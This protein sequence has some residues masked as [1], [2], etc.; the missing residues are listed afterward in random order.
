[1]LGRC[2]QSRAQRV[3]T[4]SLVAS[5]EG[6]TQMDLV[7]DKVWKGTS[8]GKVSWSPI[9]RDHPQAD[10]LWATLAFVICRICEHWYLWHPET[11]AQVLCTQR[12]T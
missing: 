6:G 11:I 5:Q 8:E 10:D 2:C 3:C 12:K 1:M 4:R 7:R 9:Y